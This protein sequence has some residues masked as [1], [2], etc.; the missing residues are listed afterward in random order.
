MYLIFYCLFFSCKIPKEKQLDSTLVNTIQNVVFVLDKNNI[1]PTWINYFN[2][3]SIE[4]EVIKIDSSHLIDSVINVFQPLTFSLSEIGESAYN[5]EYNVFPGDTVFIK[6]DSLGFPIVKIFGISAQSDILQN[7]YSIVNNRSIG[8]N[9]LLVQELSSLMIKNKGKILLSPEKSLA[10]SLGVI[11]SLN[12]LQLLDNTATNILKLRQYG[13]LCSYYLFKKNIGAFK[14]LFEKELLPN[15]QLLGSHNFFNKLVV[16]YAKVNAN[17]DLGKEE[18]DYRALLNKNSKLLGSSNKDYLLFYS[19]SKAKFYQPD[20]FHEIKELFLSEC[21]NEL[22]KTYFHESEIPPIANLDR[23]EDVLL[24]ISG[25][26]IV[27]DSL[28]A[29]FKG[30]VIY[31]DIWASWCAPCIAEMPISKELRRKY[32][33]GNVVFFF[34][35]ID[36]NFKAWVNNQHRLLLK[37]DGFSYILA[38]PKESNLL[39]LIKLNSVPRYLIFNKNGQL[40]YSKAPNPTDLLTGDIID[41]LINE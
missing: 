17:A 37:D 20:S 13:Y 8:I 29:Q 9:S 25:K 24:D 40:I 1:K 30:K 10:Y 23:A 31:L 21:K 22:L 36:N 6:Y 12:R 34:V 11:D 16:S 4:P 26:E 27:L 35:S 41:R 19:A 18:I 38:N 32:S 15:S 7:V 3:F 33:N 39:K 5:F 2:K 14:G 28:I